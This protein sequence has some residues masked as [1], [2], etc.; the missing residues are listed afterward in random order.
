MECAASLGCKR[1]LNMAAVYK[2]IRF[3]SAFYFLHIFYMCGHASVSVPV[4]VE[5]C[6]C[7][8]LCV[9]PE[10]WS[11]YHYGTAMR[12]VTRGATITRGTRGA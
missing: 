9:V 6:V 4:C 12:R 7:E 5:V 1:K 10:I 8:C 11:C 2:S 3:V